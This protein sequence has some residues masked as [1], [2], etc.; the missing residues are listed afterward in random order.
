MIEVVE[1]V[2]VY[3]VAVKIVLIVALKKTDSRL[4]FSHKTN[5]QA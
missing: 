2:V 1:V 5:G 4:D 3:V